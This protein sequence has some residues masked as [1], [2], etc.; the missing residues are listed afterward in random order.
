MYLQPRIRPF[1]QILITEQQVISRILA[2]G[3]MSVAVFA[4]IVYMLNTA[5][6]RADL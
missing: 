3:F 4:A 2:S 6:A 1:E 5:G